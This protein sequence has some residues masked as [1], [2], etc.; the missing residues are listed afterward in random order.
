VYRIIT[1]V[2]NKYEFNSKL[3]STNEIKKIIRDEI[4]EDKEE[5][6]VIKAIKI[7]DIQKINPSLNDKAKSIPK[8]VATPFPPLNFNQTG[9]ICPMNAARPDK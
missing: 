8:Y 3:F 6:F 9:N 5:Y 7:Q 2:I 4:I 1:K